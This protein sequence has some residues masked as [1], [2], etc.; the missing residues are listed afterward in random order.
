MANIATKNRI[1]GVMLL[2]LCSIIWGFAFVA[3]SNATGTLSAFAFSGMRFVFSFVGFFVV[4][5]IYTFMA[6]RAHYTLIPWSVATILGGIMCGIALYFA[7]LCQQLGIAYTTV[8]KTSFI[9]ALY[10]VIVPMIG[11]LSR[12]KP[13]V[14]SVPAIV[15]AI[16]G[17][18]F[19]CINSSF[20]M[21][22]GDAL[23]LMCAGMYSMQILF[24]ALY[25]KVCDPIRLTFVQ[26]A[27][28]AVLGVVGM[29]ITGF[30]SGMA[31][32]STIWEILYLGILSGTI[33]FTMQTIGQKS[34]APAVATLI[35]SMESVV[36]LVG[37]IIFLRQIPTVREILGCL[38]VLFA[39]VLAQIDFKKTFLKF[40][41]NKYF[42]Q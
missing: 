2:S 26:F 4:I 25:V 10:I 38:L 20:R 7:M 8:G 23:V 33:G 6:K 18:Y 11:I 36:G 29:A 21:T 24:I 39:V 19:M 31:I 13:S 1:M 3:Q 35:M 22:M 40:E 5:L 12:Q 34:V 41:S 42:L 32:G 16:L 17:F 27:T 37:G 14:F 30:P 28:A 15:I 9:T